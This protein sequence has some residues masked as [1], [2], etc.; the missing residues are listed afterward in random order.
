M[1]VSGSKVWLS[2]GWV[3]NLASPALADTALSFYNLFIYGCAV[4]LMLRGL[5]SSCS[6]FPSQRTSSRHTGSM[7]AVHRLSCSAACG[8]LANQ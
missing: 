7:A 8:I 6:G 5:F 1:K 2:W 4:T 3:A